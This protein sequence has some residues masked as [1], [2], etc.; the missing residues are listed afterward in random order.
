MASLIAAGNGSHYFSNARRDTQRGQEFKAKELVELKVPSGPRIQVYPILE[1]TALSAEV[2]HA[3]KT[4]KQAVINQKTIPV[5]EG[6]V[7]IAQ[8]LGQ[9]V[10]FG[11]VLHEHTDYLNTTLFYPVNFSN[12]IYANAASGTL[13]AGVCPANAVLGHTQ[14]LKQMVLAGTA[15]QTRPDGVFYLTVDATI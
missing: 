11:A 7:L 2:E 5:Q 10:Q 14:C 8:R 3:F 9:S 1:S 4:G 12:K 6:L 13:N 15:A